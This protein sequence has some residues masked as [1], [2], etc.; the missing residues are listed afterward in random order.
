MPVISVPP[1]SSASFGADIVFDFAVGLF[2]YPVDIRYLP[3]IDKLS[4]FFTV[5]N[6]IFGFL[7][8][9]AV[10]RGQLFFVGGV[11]V[12]PAA[13]RRSILN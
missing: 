12:N 6:N 8:S 9:D 1:V 3:R 10:E 13:V 4:V 11:Y 5:A 2:A 7:F